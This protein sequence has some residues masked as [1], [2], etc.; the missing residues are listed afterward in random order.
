MLTLKGLTPT[1]MLPSGVLSGGKEKLQNGK[2]DTKSPSS[3]PLVPWSPNVSKHRRTSN[4]VLARI[5]CLFERYEPKPAVLCGFFNPNEVLKRSSPLFL[6]PCSNSFS[7]FSSV[8][9]SSWV[10]PH[11]T[12]CFCFLKSSGFDLKCHLCLFLSLFSLETAGIIDC[13]ASMLLCFLLTVQ[14]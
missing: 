2:S 9:L 11:L 5:S 12:S 8:F 13:C 4:T 7:R 3:P 10:C 6:R 14:I 1:G